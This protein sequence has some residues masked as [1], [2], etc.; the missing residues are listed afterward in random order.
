[1]HEPYDAHDTPAATTDERPGFRLI[2]SAEDVLWLFGGN[3]QHV[4]DVIRAA[5]EEDKL[6]QQQAQD[7]TA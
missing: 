1:M 7:K 4:Y 5:V 6:R 2:E 3:A